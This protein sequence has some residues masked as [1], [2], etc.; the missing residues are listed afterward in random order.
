MNILA[1]R[2]ARLGDVVLLLPA[3]ASLKSAYPDARLTFLTGHRC[4]PVAQ[5]CP[6]I[7]E[8]LAV[9][10][11]AMRDGSTLAALWVMARLVR[12]VRRRRFDLVIDFH[13]FRETNLLA[14]IS[15]ARDR[16]AMK[17]YNAPYLGFCFNRPPVLEDKALHVS[18]MFQKVVGAITG[19][20]ASP[21]GSLVLPEEL[22]SYATDAAPPGPR[23]AVYIDAPVAERIWPPERF[24]AVADFA[25]ETLGAN[26]L[27]LSS[28]EGAKLAARLEKASRHPD[29]IAVFTD[30]GI[31]ELTALIASSRLLVSNDTGPMHIG[32]AVGV[33]T[34]GLFS[35]GYPE[36]F[37][38]IG[39]C[40]RFIRANPIDKI[41]TRVVIGLVEEMWTTAI[42]GLRC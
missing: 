25:V 23:I 29:R 17:R 26:V 20:V 40:D 37:R 14:R 41:E 13:S 35:V 42:P 5:L 39:A 2:F 11:I 7:D 9:D 4:A 28:K 27:V 1:M 38:P 36:H 31:R 8:V 3:L 12:D 15:G 22:R 30:I 10:R 6:A 32:P 33:R 21:E 19:R 24:A 34:L 16:I 18:E